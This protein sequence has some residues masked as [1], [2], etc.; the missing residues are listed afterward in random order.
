MN[1]SARA[2]SDDDDVLPVFT[3]GGIAQRLRV[4]P[5]TL[6]IWERKGLVKPRRLGR[7]RLYSSRDLALLTAI[8]ELIQKRKLNIE[9]VRA[10]L[11]RPRCW[12]VKKCPPDMRKSCSFYVSQVWP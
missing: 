5:A 6:R 11:A 9:G 12:E 2:V 7:N 4:C 10:L 3:I 1:P 8:K